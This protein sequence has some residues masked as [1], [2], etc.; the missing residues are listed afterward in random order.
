M[1]DSIVRYFGITVTSGI[2][3]RLSSSGPI[4]DPCG[5]P[6]EIL[7]LSDSKLYTDNKKG[8]SIP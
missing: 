2:I 4:T 7:T 1:S 6:H 5:T 8:T 3:Y